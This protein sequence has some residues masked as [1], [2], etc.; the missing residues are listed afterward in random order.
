[1]SVKKLWGTYSRKHGFLWWICIGFWWWMIPLNIAIVFGIFSLFFKKKPKNKRV[2]VKVLGT[3]GVTPKNQ[4]YASKKPKSGVQKEIKSNDQLWGELNKEACD[5]FANGE[6]GRDSYLGMYDILKS[7][8]KRED[9]LRMLLHVMFLDV[10]GNSSKLFCVR[11]AEYKNIDAGI[12]KIMGWTSSFSVDVSIV[13][14]TKKELM[15]YKDICSDNAV[16][17][18]AKRHSHPDQIC[19]PKEFLDIIHMILAGKSSDS[20]S[21]DILAPMLKRNYISVLKRHGIKYKD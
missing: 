5:A 15:R 12:A 9:A 13:P 20:M 2:K 11:I 10:N 4:N 16:L 19:T 18:A 21:A 8:G 3:Y 17:D 6:S 14:Y 1:M 7:E